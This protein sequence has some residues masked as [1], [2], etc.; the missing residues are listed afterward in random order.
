MGNYEYIIWF[1]DQNYFNDDFNFNLAKA[2]VYVDNAPVYYG[3]EES[4]VLKGL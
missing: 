2:F 1:L 4:P 3:I